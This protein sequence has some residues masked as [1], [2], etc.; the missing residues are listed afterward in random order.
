MGKKNSLKKEY[1]ELFGDDYTYTSWSVNYNKN[2]D[3]EVKIEYESVG[4]LAI[5][6]SAEYYGTVTCFSYRL[7]K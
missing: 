5:T 1:E 4:E 3:C 7:N 2:D 6:V